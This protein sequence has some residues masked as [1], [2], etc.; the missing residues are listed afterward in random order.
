[1]GIGD[2]TDAEKSGNGT[3]DLSLQ[4]RLSDPCVLDHPVSSWIMNGCLMHM[5]QKHVFMVS[6]HSWQLV[7]LSLDI[8]IT[9]WPWHGVGRGLL[10]WRQPAQHEGSFSSSSTHILVPTVTWKHR[11]RKNPPWQVISENVNGVCRWCF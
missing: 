1:M 4:S 11:K 6:R 8:Y 5:L 9:V 2:T 7:L 10:L 3:R